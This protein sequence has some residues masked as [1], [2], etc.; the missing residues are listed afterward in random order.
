M[1]RPIESFL[2]QFQLYN[3][4]P[5]VLLPREGRPSFSP[6]SF[7]VMIKNDKF[8]WRV[9]DHWLDF[10]K[11]LC[12]NGNFPDYNTDDYRWQDSDQ[13]GLW[14]AL[15]KTHMEFFPGVVKETF[16]VC[17]ESTGLLA[18]ANNA[19]QN[20]INSYFRQVNAKLGSFGED[21]FK[22]PSDQPIVWS[23]VKSGGAALGIWHSRPN[24]NVMIPWTFGLHTKTPPRNWP[25]TMNIELELCKTVHGC[26]ANYTKAG[27]LQ[28]GC[29]G[30]QYFPVAENS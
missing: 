19:Y 6:S 8:G 20:K 24:S 16:P 29:N 30:V 25:G 28:I 14:Y 15:I 10:G 4:S 17:N 26:Y 9:L 3:K 13:P 11:G 7:T 2:K 23:T 21:L 27:E 22:I 5:S 18:D 12:K 1:T